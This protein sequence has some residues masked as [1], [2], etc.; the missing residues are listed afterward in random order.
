M[1]P[2]NMVSGHKGYSVLLFGNC[3]YALLLC[4]FESPKSET[5]FEDS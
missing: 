1:L 2:Q 3:P 5:S 4:L